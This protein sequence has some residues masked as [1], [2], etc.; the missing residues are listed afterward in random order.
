[1][2]VNEAMW[3][4]LPCIVSDQVGCGPDLVAAQGTGEVFPLHDEAAL[5]AAMVRFAR[6]PEQRRACGVRARTVI[7]VLFHCLRCRGHR[8]RGHC[9]EERTAHM[10]SAASATHLRIPRQSVSR[11]AQPVKITFVP[12]L[13]IAALW[14]FSPLPLASWQWFALCCWCCCPGGPI[15]SG[16]R[17]ISSDFHCSL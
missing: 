11:T 10:T 15:A 13:L 12:V 16:R 3:S 4:G 6:N 14:A 17:A 9:C 8:Q 5:A 1:M 7:Q 2:V